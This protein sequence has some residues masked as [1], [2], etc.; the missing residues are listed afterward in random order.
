M[1]PWFSGT[2]TV[3]AA[4]ALTPFGRNLL[5]YLQRRRRESEVLETTLQE[6]TELRV[7][8]SEVTERLDATEYRLVQVRARYPESRVPSPMGPP[9]QAAGAAT[10]H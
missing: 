7:T 1:L 3:G 10:P 4:L 9:I 5:H 6:L 8:L 2:L